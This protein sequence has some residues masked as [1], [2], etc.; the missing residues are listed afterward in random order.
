MIKLKNSIFPT[1][2]IITACLIGFLIF[3]TIQTDT[4][5]RAKD[6]TLSEI[7]NV[8]VTSEYR[9]GWIDAL[10]RIDAWYHAPVNATMT[11]TELF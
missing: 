8:N 9:R 5:N 7:N 2:A 4:F 1:V 6:K 10:K 3:N 11:T